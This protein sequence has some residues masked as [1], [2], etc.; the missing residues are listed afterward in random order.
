MELG[1]SKEQK[2]PAMGWQQREKFVEKG[3]Q[4]TAPGKAF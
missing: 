2:G 3:G 1:K 4:R